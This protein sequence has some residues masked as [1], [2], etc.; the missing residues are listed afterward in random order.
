LH[1]GA[2]SDDGQ[3]QFLVHFIIASSSHEVNMAETHAVV[4]ESEKR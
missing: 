2:R 1:M 4:H 3:M